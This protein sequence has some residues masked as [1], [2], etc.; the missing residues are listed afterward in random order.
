MK[1]CATDPFFA[2]DFLGGQNPY[3]ILVPVAES[4]VITED[5][6]ADHYAD[7]EIEKLLSAYLSRE[8]ETIDEVK[9][10]FKVGLEELLGLS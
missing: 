6:E 5:T 7:K 3:A 9:L 2:C 8:I 10:Q 4:I 1:Q